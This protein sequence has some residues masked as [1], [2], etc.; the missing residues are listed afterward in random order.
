MPCVFPGL[1]APIQHGEFDL[2]HQ[3]YLRRM[4]LSTIWHPLTGSGSDSIT[5]RETLMRAFWAFY[6]AW[7]SFA[8]LDAADAALSIISVVVFRLDRPEDWPPLFGSLSEAYSIRRFWGK[9]WHRLVVRPYSNFGRYAA[10]RIV[11]LRPDSKAERMTTLFAVFFLSGVA[12]GVVAWWELGQCA[13]WTR[14]VAWF[15]GN[16]LAG[17]LEVVVARVFRQCTLKMGWTNH[18]RHVNESS[19]LLRAVGFAWV[20]G[21]FFW[22]VPKWMWPKLDCAIE[23]VS[24]GK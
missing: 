22:S 5:A 18:W 4:H 1:F 14:D 15:C 2:L 8:M 13:Y 19:G 11:G 3:T 16:F 9:F 12:H 10:R 6:W 21:F 17:A 24:K 7:C 20:F 23:Q